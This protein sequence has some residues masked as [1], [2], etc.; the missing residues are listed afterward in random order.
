M[1]KIRAKQIEKFWSHVKK[2]E[3]GCW[4]WQLSVSDRGYGRVTFH[5]KT[6]RTHIV[7]YFLSKGDIPKGKFVCHT[8]DNP[9]CVNPDHLWLGDPKDNT[10]DMIVKGRLIRLRSK[11][12][13]SISKYPG[14]SFRKEKKSK[15]WRA[16][17]MRDY[18]TVWGEEFDTE[19]EAHQAR[20]KA[21]KSLL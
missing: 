7:A 4:E 11:H 20:M 10:H 13:D 16:R 21:L 2:V 8:C 18:S 17:I 14:V 3:S 19:E 12:R 1:M 9:R 15:P 6:Y 5:P